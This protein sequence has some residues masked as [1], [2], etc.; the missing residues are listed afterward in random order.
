MKIPRPF[1]P[2]EVHQD[3]LL[4]KVS[5]VGRDMVFGADSLLQSVTS[6]GDELLAAPIRLVGLEDGEPIIWDKNYPDNE[7]QAFI[8]SRSDDKVVLCGAM[9]TPRFIVNTCTSIEYDGNIAVDLKIMPMGKTVAQVFGLSSTKQLRYELNQLWLEIPLKKSIATM[10]SVFP[11]SVYHLADGTEVPSAPTSNSGL[12]NKQG[13]YFPFKALM[14][15]GNEEK[16]LGFFAENWK[17]WQPEEKEKT[18]E[19]FEDSEAVV[20]RVHLLDNHPDAWKM[21]A[22]E[23]GSYRF[24]PI[25]FRFGLQATPVKPFPVKPYIHNGLHLDCFIKVKGNYYD[26]LTDQNRFDRLKEKG[27]TTL[28]LHEKWNKEQN[29][30]EISEFTTEQ[31]KKITTECH[32][33]GI[34]V[35]TYFGYEISSLSP[36]FSELADQVVMSDSTGHMD[37]GW[38]RVPFQRDYRVCYNNQ[39]SDRFVQGV[40]KLMDT[41]HIDGVYLDGTSRPD[42]CHNLNHGCGWIDRD[43]NLCGTYPVLAVREMFKKLYSEV[44]ARGGMINVHAYGMQN[45][46]ALPFIDLSWYGENLQTDYCHG[47]FADV[48]L[49]YFRSEYTGRNMGVPCELIAYENRPIWNFENAIAISIIHGILPR[50]NDIEKP[51]D[52]M[53]EIWHIM[54]SFPLEQSQWKPYWNNGAQITDP[55]IKV[56]YYKYSALDGSVM[57][58]LFC[59]NVTTTRVEGAELTLKE[60]VIGN[61]W[62]DLLTREKVKNVFS[63][64]PYKYKIILVK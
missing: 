52:M 62:V 27:V 53:S 44:H 24:T 30:F 26:F 23:Q 55:R 50:P 21:V 11:N 47:K 22:P 40:A 20:L 6:C 19:V 58:L 42:Y 4:H 25:S 10:F 56:S 33:R 51:L 32:R 31:L 13:M 34:R 12:V 38:F 46:T 59:S 15:I 39:W 60:E 5:V 18:I 57:L 49:N 64:D 48:P 7:S 14:W 41:C 36:V 35:L 17:N 9:A 54:D 61:T 28:I 43:G 8:Q 29:W 2:I 1:F 16:G 37:G 45:F 3:G 63:L